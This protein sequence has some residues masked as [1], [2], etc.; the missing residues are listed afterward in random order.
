MAKQHKC[1]NIETGEIY[2]SQAQAARS[3]GVPIHGIKKL[4]EKVGV[5]Q[6]AKRNINFLLN[7]LSG[8]KSRAEKAK[9]EEAKRK[10]AARREIERM[11][12]KVE[13]WFD[14]LMD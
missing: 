12:D 7:N 2:E 9:T 1:R 6:K 4:V 3:L 5:A 13:D 14:G 8:D 11:N 10:L